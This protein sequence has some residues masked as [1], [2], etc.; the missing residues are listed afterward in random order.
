MNELE[1]RTTKDFVSVSGFPYNRTGWDNGGRWEDHWRDINLEQ[2][3][4]A[5]HNIATEAAA[6][7]RR[8]ATDLS[9]MLRV[10]EQAKLHGCVIRLQ[11]AP[12]NPLAYKKPPLHP[13]AQKVQVHLLQAIAQV[14]PQIESISLDRSRHR[15]L[16][17]ILVGLNDEVRESFASLREFTLTPIKGDY[18]RW[19]RVDDVEIARAILTSAQH[20]RKLYLHVSYRLVGNKSHK[21]AQRWTPYLLLANGLGELESLTLLWISCGGAHAH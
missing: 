19:H 16:E 15:F 14:K 1:L 12:A 10:I 2:Y 21:L 8:G 6:V 4:Q 11:L 7:E 20:L 3:C 13:Q 18:N 5:G 9:V 17:E